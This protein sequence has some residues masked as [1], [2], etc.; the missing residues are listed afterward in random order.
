MIHIHLGKGLPAERNKQSSEA[1]VSDL[2]AIS[3][4]KGAQG[5]QPGQH[6]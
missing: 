4:A 1:F 3:E 5:R 6:A 2:P